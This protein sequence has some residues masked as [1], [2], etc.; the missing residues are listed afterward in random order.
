MIHDSRRGPD[1]AARKH[2][3]MTGNP[4]LPGSPEACVPDRGGAIRGPAGRSHRKSADHPAPRPGVRRRGAYAATPPDQCDRA[5][6]WRS[7]HGRSSFA[8]G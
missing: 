3:G 6:G 2:P 5:R 8:G 1:G 7:R 4:K